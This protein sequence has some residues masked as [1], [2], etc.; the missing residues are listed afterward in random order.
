MMKEC[1]GKIASLL[2]PLA[3]IQHPRKNMGKVHDNGPRTDT[4]CAESR[5]HLICQMLSIEMEED[6][7]ESGIH[8]IS[9]G[10][11]SRRQACQPAQ[12]AAYLNQKHDCHKKLAYMGMS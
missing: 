3:D 1:T 9:L 10:N 8:W 6:R 4:L 12:N 5:C 11:D 2:L 7:P